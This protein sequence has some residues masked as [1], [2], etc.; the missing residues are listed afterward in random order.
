[1]IKIEIVW[2]DLT[3]DEQIMSAFTKIRVDLLKSI[4]DKNKKTDDKLDVLPSYIKRG[5]N[6]NNISHIIIDTPE[7]DNQYEVNENGLLKA[8]TTNI[9]IV[10]ELYGIL[11]NDQQIQSAT[12][13]CRHDDEETQ[14]LLYNVYSDRANSEN[15]QI[16]IKRS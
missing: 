5:C 7:A 13:I 11:F 1:M 9:R 10:K 3:Q 2:K 6:Y 12:I 16:I 15:N 4:S 8:E 14:Y